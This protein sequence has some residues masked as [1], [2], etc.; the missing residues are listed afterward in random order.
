MTLPFI[1]SIS[2]G[3]SNPF[4]AKITYNRTLKH[5][6]S[7]RTF[8]Y[9]PLFSIPWKAKRNIPHRCSPQRDI[10]SNIE[11]HVVVAFQGVVDA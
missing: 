7:L 2:R 9:D 4:G 3:T 6:I 1:L 8:G 10:C 5:R 11:A